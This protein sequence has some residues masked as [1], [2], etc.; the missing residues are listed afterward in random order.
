MTSNSINDT[1]AVAIVQKAT[2]TVWMLGNTVVAREL[3][4]RGLLLEGVGYSPL[5]APQAAAA[6][7]AILSWLS[8]E[9]GPMAGVPVGVIDDL[10]EI[11]SPTA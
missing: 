2:Q 9:D 5:K 1:P 3:K 6:A 10:S 7:L 8:D 4:G 11:A